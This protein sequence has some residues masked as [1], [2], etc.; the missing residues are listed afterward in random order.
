MSEP[1]AD[2]LERRLLIL[3]PVGKDAALIAASLD[4][5]A[6]LCFPCVRHGTHSRPS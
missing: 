3:A 2:R 6:V 5:D 4:K 1:H